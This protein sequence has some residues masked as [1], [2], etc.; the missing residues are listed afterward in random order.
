[1]YKSYQIVCSLICHLYE[2]EYEILLHFNKPSYT[3]LYLTWCNVRK[4]KSTVLFG[5]SHPNTHKP[6]ILCTSD[7]LVPL[8]MQIGRPS[9]TIYGGLH[10]HLSKARSQFVSFT[11]MF[12]ISYHEW[13]LLRWGWLH[14]WVVIVMAILTMVMTREMNIFHVIPPN[15]LTQVVESF[16]VVRQISTYST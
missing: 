6:S 11:K 8:S 10:Q 4:R 1:M 14:W 5:S 16:P 2:F 15:R 7:S 12:S 3:T 9:Y 13:W